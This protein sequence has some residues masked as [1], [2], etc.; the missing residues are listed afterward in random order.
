ME[1]CGVPDGKPLYPALIILLSLTIT[2][3][4]F[5]LLLGE[6]LDINKAIILMILIYS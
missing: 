6:R 1:I 4:T 5:N 2:L 3:P